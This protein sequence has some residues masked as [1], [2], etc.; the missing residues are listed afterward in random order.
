MTHTQGSPQGSLCA[1][2]LP[3]G[4]YS[5]SLAEYFVVL[6]GFS[7]LMHQHIGK[8]IF[9]L[10]SYVLEGRVSVLERQEVIDPLNK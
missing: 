6:G 7:S 2:T 8:D 5:K 4:I 3:F 9:L 1:R 10:A